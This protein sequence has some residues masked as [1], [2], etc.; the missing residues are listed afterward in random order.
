M[1][2][3]AAAVV[4]RAAAVLA[5]GG[6]EGVA[7]TSGTAQSCLATSLQQQQQQQQQ[8]GSLSGLASGPGR[9]G[10][11]SSALL[12]AA[13]KRKVTPSRKKIRNG[14]KGIDFIPL[15]MQCSVCGRARLP[16]IVCDPASCRWR[17]MKYDYAEALQRKDGVAA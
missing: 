6:R 7:S 15:A 16:H 17:L 8:L 13:P 3:A 2:A 1:R 12:L 10:F 5:A 11:H 9:L 4:R 14:P